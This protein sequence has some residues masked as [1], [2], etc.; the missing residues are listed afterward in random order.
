MKLVLSI[1][2]FLFA[3][4]FGYMDVSEDIVQ[5]L[6][7]GKASDVVKNF[8]EKVSLKLV[9]Q[10][11][12]LSRSQAEANLKNFFEKHPVKNFGS[13]HVSNNSNTLQYLTGSLE[14]S[15]GKFRVSV[16]IKRSL[17]TQFRIENENE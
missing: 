1:F 16:L 8:D 13:V 7:S 4:L 3:L 11:D 5:G 14:T 12:V 10:E 9:V 6:K 15:N 17:V 2:Y